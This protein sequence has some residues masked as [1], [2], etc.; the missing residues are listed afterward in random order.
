M[1][2]ALAPMNAVSILLKF[3]D[4]ISREDAAEMGDGIDERIAPD[5]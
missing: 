2:F 5:D 4:T 1:E 3:E